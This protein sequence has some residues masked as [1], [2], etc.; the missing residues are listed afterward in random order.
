VLDK[1]FIHAII[2]VV[3]TLFSFLIYFVFSSEYLK[4][5]YCRLNWIEHHIHLNTIFTTW[6]CSN[7]FLR[8]NHPIPYSR[9]FTLHTYTLNLLSHTSLYPT[10]IPSSQS[11]HPVYSNIQVVDSQAM[12]RRSPITSFVQIHMIHEPVY[13]PT[14]SILSI[15]YPW[16]QIIIKKN[17]AAVREREETG[18]GRGGCGT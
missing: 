16:I 7:V 10:P 2:R 13:P 17:S 11:T 1:K 5:W 18:Y 15:P 4:F 9:L 14:L 8:I 12:T 3:S 6:D